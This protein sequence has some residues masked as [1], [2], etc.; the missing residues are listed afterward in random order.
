MKASLLS[1][2]TEI[3]FGQITNTNTVFLSQKLNEMGIDVI[4]HHTVGDNPERLADIIRLS[5]K[6]CD[7]VIT[8][9][10]LG[11]TQD[12]MTKEIA[13]Q[14]FGDTLEKRSELVKA[15][16][17]RMHRYKGGFTSNNYKQA[18]MPTRAIVF[19]NPV[20][21]APGFALESATEPGKYIACMPGPPREMTAMF[22]NHLRPW[23]LSMSDGSI[24]YRELRTFGIG[25]S[26]LETA[27]LPIIDGQT[28]PTIATYAK[29][30]ESSVRIASKRPTREEAVAA[31][32]SMVEEVD[33]LVG[34]YIYSYDN[35]ELV[36]VVVRKL[37]KKGLTLSSA[38]SCTG[39]MFASTLTDV[40]GVSACFD[41]GLVTY[42]DKAKIEELGVSSETLDRYGAV[43]EKTALE[44][45]EGVRR[46]SGSDIGIS[47]T[48]IAGPDGGTEEKQVGLTYIGFVYGDRK[49]C[50]KIDR[51]LKER[52]RNRKYATM[53]MLDIINREI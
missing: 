3:L 7:L 18:Y 35:E 44:M 34:E 33:K 42:S 37:I 48:G 20:G 36:N 39:G 9:G 12:D 52:R 17:E 15:L 11:P 41:R 21:T 5:L 46:V 2:G 31:V 22:E 1:V 19:K 53:S 10:G 4:Y 24:F 26:A 43:S 29:E 27:L 16:E 30:S 40:P 14:V 28:D 49:F 50:R 51:A 25:E 8:T 32:D 47:V 13:C 45:A 38:E 6:D 23:L